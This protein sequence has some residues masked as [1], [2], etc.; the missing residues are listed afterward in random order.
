MSVR[1]AQHYPLKTIHYLQYFIILID[2]LYYNE[3][4]PF[5]KIAQTASNT[6]QARRFF[7]NPRTDP[8]RTPV[9]PQSVLLRSGFGAME[10]KK[11]GQSRARDATMPI[12]FYQKMILY[13]FSQHFDLRFLKLHITFAAKTL[14]TQQPA[15]A[16][17]VPI[18]TNKHQQTQQTN[19]IDNTC[20]D[21]SIVHCLTLLRG[22]WGLPSY[23]RPTGGRQDQPALRCHAQHQRRH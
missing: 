11:S 13:I 6:K 7:Y 1:I 14:Q 8:S 3:R 5:A 10:R 22:G 18:G 19:D 2:E 16:R 9:V 4:S 20:K 21:E 15:Q 12:Q 17:H 23:P